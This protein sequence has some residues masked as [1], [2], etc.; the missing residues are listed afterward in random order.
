MTDSMSTA[1][2][3]VREFSGFGLMGG[4]GLAKILARVLSFAF[5]LRDRFA[6]FFFS[7]VA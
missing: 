4:F 6:I 2:E 5:A 1:S 7:A 3:K